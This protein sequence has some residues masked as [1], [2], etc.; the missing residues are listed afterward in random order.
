MISL[1]IHFIKHPQNPRRQE[2][3][4]N[5]STEKTSLILRLDVKTK[6]KFDLYCK[7]Q[8]LSVSKAIRQ[9]IEEKVGTPEP[10]EMKHSTEQRWK[11]VNT[12]LTHSEHRSMQ[13]R[14]LA[15]KTTS[16]KWLLGLIR[17]RLIKAPQLRAE[18]IQAISQALF[19]LQSIG[20]NLNQLVKHL[21]TAPHRVE[22][23]QLVDVI[24]LQDSIRSTTRSVTNLIKAASVRDFEHV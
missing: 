17:E 22:H 4:L 15:E 9:F 23:I 20:R 24:E 10:D 1:Y 3:F 6:E 19:R 18:E 11:V 21:N 7:S 14:V 12:R 5:V 13:V 2:G 16:S 8:D